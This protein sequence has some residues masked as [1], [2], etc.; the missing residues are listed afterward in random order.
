MSKAIEYANA[1]RARAVPL[2][3]VR[4]ALS[5]LGMVLFSGGIALN[6]RFRV[7]WPLLIG[8]MLMPFGAFLAFTTKDGSP[9]QR[10]MV[11]ASLIINVIGALFVLWLLST[12]RI[13]RIDY[14]R[15]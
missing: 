8:A 14:P 5:L 11:M 3:T 2:V 13:N 9:W 4:I 10:R 6:V 15:H 1:G 7:D 12:A